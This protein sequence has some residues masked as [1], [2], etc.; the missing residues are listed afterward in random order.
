MVLP[1][2]HILNDDFFTWIASAIDWVIK[3]K[4]KYNTKIVNLSLGTPANN[5]ISSDPLVKAVNEAVKA[6][7]TVVVAAG[8]S[9][10]NAQ[11]ILSP[12]NSSAAITVGAVDDRSVKAGNTYSIAP[13]SSRGPTK[14][15]LRK[16]DVV[17]PGVSIKSLSN[18][19]GYKTL[20]GTSMATP[21]VTGSLALLLS[22]NES[23]GPKE[24]KSEIIKSCTSLHEKPD[25]QG[26]GIINMSK[27]FNKTSPKPSKPTRPSRPSRSIFFNPDFQRPSRPSR[28]RPAKTP[29]QEVAK[30][31][32]ESV[33]K[34]Q[35]YMSDALVFLLFLILILIRVI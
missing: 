21:V 9:G 2:R 6:G 28:Q 17:A 11:T 35:D 19:D 18:T 24:L 1:L 25:N 10:P 29:E 34:S 16:P 13:F 14:E 32:E 30:P 27:L 3:T 23:L 5:P 31:A 8:N 26:A 4:D 12:G 15:G 7:L 33:L 20:S 22:K